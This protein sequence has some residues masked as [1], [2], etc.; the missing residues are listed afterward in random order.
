MSASNHIEMPQKNADPMINVRPEYLCEIIAR[1]WLTAAC[2]LS[3]KT[4]LS[5]TELRD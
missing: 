5:A 3:C 4:V 1:T 2:D